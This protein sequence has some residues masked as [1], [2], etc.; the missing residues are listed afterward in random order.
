MATDG[1]ATD[2]TATG[3]S[4]TTEGAKAP[5]GVPEA[6]AVQTAVTQAAATTAAAT[7]AAAPQAARAEPAEAGDGVRR[8][9]VEAVHRALRSQILDGTIAAGTVLSQVDLAERFGVSRTPLREAL[10]MLQEEGLVEAKRNHQA[11]VAT[12]ALVDL[13]AISAQRILLSALATQI[14][15]PWLSDPLVDELEAHREAMRQAAA[16]DDREAWRR[17]DSAF[18]GA[19]YKHAPASL[20]NEVRRLAERNT[21][22]HVVWEREEPHHDPLTEVEHERIVAAC[23]ARDPHEA[24][25]AVARHHARIAIGVL[26]RTAPEHEPRVI[27]AAL[28]LVLGSSQ[29]GLPAAGAA[30]SQ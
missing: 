19:H 3:R 21:L 6:A 16:A 17:A 20:S 9:G 26:A 4:A 11:R 2:E 1:T 7:T 30:L 15:V 27:R 10:R 23:R 8:V 25:R 13:E 18:H 5:A 12:F 29:T 22:Y 14:S 24:A 28:Q